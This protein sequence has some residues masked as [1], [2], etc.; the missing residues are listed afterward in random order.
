MHDSSRAL[1]EAG[2]SIWL[3]ELSRE[4]GVILADSTRGTYKQPP[5]L[6]DG[7]T[8]WMPGTA[9]ATIGEAPPALAEACHDVWRCGDVG[10]RLVYARAE[11]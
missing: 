2:L 6:L 5:H 1:P 8:G 3:D 4:R 9:Y 10:A 7:D 11:G